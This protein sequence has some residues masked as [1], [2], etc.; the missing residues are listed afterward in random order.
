MKFV[1]KH[2]SLFYTSFLLTQ[3]F[4]MFFINL[5]HQIIINSFIFLLMLLEIS[6]QNITNDIS[7]D[8]TYISNDSDLVFYR[9]CHTSCGIMIH[10]AVKLTSMH[11]LNIEK[12]IITFKTYN[13]HVL[14]FLQQ[15]VASLGCIL[16]N[17]QCLLL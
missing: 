3:H 17:P 16:F 8:K 12:Q 10:K 13:Y 5:N 6:V 1:D 14:A 7:R 15:I 2:L 9:K 11:F 4:L